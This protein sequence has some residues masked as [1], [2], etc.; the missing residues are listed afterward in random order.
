MTIDLG[1]AGI[2]DAVEIGAGGFGVVYK[3]VEADLGRTVAIKVL[4][5]NLD[6]GARYRFERERRA[7]GRLSGHPN[8]VTIYRGGYTAAG[9]AYLVM[10]FLERGSLADQ[11]NERGPVAWVDALAYGVQLAGALETS[12]QAGVLHRDI[13]PANILLSRLG[14]TKLCD[15]GIARLQGALETK[16]TVVTASL[17][18]APPDIIS[19]HR[20]DARSDV[21]SLASTIYELVAGAPAFV[22]VTDESIVP[23]IARIAQEPLPIL[24]EGRLPTPAMRAIDQAM[25]KEPDD[26]PSTAKEFAELLVSVQRELGVQQS[27]I[28][29]ETIADGESANELGAAIPYP[30][31][32]GEALPAPVARSPHDATGGSPVPGST[33]GATEISGDQPTYPPPTPGSVSAQTVVTGGTS[34]PPPTSN[35]GQGFTDTGADGTRVAPSLRPEPIAP[36]P[37]PGA[38]TPAGTPP[39]SPPP[40]SSGDVPMTPASQPTSVGASSSADGGGLK[41]AIMAGGLVA[42][43]LVIAA[44]VL[45]VTGNGDDDTATDDTTVVDD[46]TDSAAADGETTPTTTQDLSTRTTAEPFPSTTGPGTGGNDYETYISAR[47]DT[48]TITVKVPLEWSDITTSLGRDGQPLLVA[49]PTI[50]GEGGFYDGFGTPGVSITVEPGAS[51]DLDAVLDE[52]NETACTRQSR[53][54]YP[55]PE[56]MTEGFTSCD[57]TDT[58]L[59]HIVF[60]DRLQDLTVI[61]RVQIVTSPQDLAAANTIVDSLKL[62]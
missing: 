17:G 22:R 46:G 55:R 3:A 49:A 26:R 44:V 36:S 14:T 23:I 54:A 2:T 27:A 15:F 12:H 37:V 24:D 28:P 20:P 32:T 7:M 53:G 45:A 51:D 13:K 47:D 1:I 41:L 38:G 42:A 30:D 60:N 43:V 16:S 8:I 56:S 4:S 11:L 9:S 34:L 5:G 21:Y 57:G 35:T 31:A 48:G 19:G 29:I 33:S 40:T 50:E 25:S 10:E 59:I 18:H 52:Y 39:V 61:V 6:E 62:G 58:D